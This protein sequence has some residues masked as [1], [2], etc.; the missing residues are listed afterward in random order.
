MVGNSMKSD[1][2]PAIEAGAWGVH[3]PYGLEWALEA[4]E[5]PSEASRFRTIQALNALPSLLSALG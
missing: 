3:V 1:V 4:A 2:I 5:P